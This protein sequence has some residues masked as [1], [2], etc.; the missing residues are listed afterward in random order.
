[1]S[2]TTRAEA[3]VGTTVAVALHT[4]SASY[5]STQVL[6]Q[7]TAYVPEFA[8]TALV[9]PNGS[10]KSTLLAVLADVISPTH[11][12][13]RRGTPERPAFVMQRSAVADTLPLTVRDTVA[14]GRWPHRRPLR[15]LTH[16]DQKIVTDSMER[17]GIGDLAERQLGQLSGGQR[18]RALV[19]QGLAQCAPLLLLDEPTTG[20]DATAR[21]YISRVLG[22]VRDAGTTVVHA[23]HDFAEAM[24]ADHCLLLA[25]GR[26]VAEGPPTAVLTPEVVEDV[27]KVPKLPGVGTSA[28]ASAGT[29]SRTSVVPAD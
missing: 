15:R 28:R 26:L 13:I 1:M 24:R 3:T 20:L 23:T 19:A 7:V 10:G 5:G 21:Q 25:D 14:M 4:L 2:V 17:L 27:W 16:A 12:E 29:C 9:G 22:G 6:H 8:T 18:Q 11:G